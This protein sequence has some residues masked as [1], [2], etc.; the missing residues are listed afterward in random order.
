MHVENCGSLLKFTILWY[1]LLCALKFVLAYRAKSALFCG[2]ELCW[3]EM[4]RL[5]AILLSKMVI[6]I[7]T[8]CSRR[9]PTWLEGQHLSG[10][11]VLSAWTSVSLYLAER[12]E[13]LASL[14]SLIFLGPTPVGCQ[15]QSSFYGISPK[16]QYLKSVLC[17]A[18]WAQDSGGLV[19]FFL[20]GLSHGEGVHL[21]KLELW[22]WLWREFGAKWVSK[23]RV[24]GHLWTSDEMTLTI[25]LVL[26][27][28]RIRTAWTAL[29]CGA[30]QSNDEADGVPAVC[31]LN[32]PVPHP[33]PACP[34]P[35]CGLIWFLKCS[36]MLHLLYHLDGTKSNLYF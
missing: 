29:E 15:Q 30:G 12:V 17:S 14:V 16:E 7:F 31:A 36:C 22:K 25:T 19:T 8:H 18:P 5:R 6:K 32:A 21:L 1:L 11:P 23:R 4:F 13:T 10:I 26:Y 27:W 20:G 9:D 3:P 35:L 33:E 34:P 24:P 2:S 28:G